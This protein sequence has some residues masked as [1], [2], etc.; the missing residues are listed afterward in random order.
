MRLRIDDSCPAAIAHLFVHD[1]AM[2]A[3]V[4]A[5]IHDSTGQL[6]ELAPG[7]HRLELPLGQLDLNAGKYSFVISIQDAATH[8][9]L[10]RAQG[11]RPFGV[12]AD[13]THWGK[14]V[15]PVVAKALD[16]RA[17]A[18]KLCVDSDATARS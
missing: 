1:E 14:I 10:V 9:T 8:V 13:R 15:R 11:V 17:R 18:A 6:L 16:V 12:F 3:V 7:E 4:C 5:P 2:A